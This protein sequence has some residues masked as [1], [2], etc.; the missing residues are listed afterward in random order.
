MSVFIKKMEI[1]KEERSLKFLRGISKNFKKIRNILK[2]KKR[3]PEIV[4]QKKKLGNK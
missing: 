2:V 1:I 3:F 4:S